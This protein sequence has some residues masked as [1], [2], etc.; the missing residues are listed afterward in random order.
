[1]NAANGEEDCTGKQEDPLTGADADDDMGQPC[2][3]DPR[4]Q[5][6]ASNTVHG[7]LLERDVVTW[8]SAEA[9]WRRNIGGAFLPLWR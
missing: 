4:G 6:N 9:L 7:L 5:K 8:F 3:E 2:K 1:M